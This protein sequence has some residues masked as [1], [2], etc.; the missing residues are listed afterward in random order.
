MTDPGSTDFVPVTD[1]IAVFDNDGTLWNEKPL[2]I[3]LEYEISYI[4]E[5]VKRKPEFKE[6]VLFRELAAGNLAILK[7]YDSFD[8]IHALFAA[9]DGQH[10]EDYNESV[11]NFLTY[12]KHPRFERPYK[13]MVYQPM[14]GL[15][16][17]LQAN[18]FNVFIVTGG[19]ISFARTVSEEIYNIPAEN[20]IGSSIQFRYVSDSSGAYIIRT[21]K[22][23]SANDKHIKPANI[24]L[25]IGKKP[26]FAAGNSDGDY[27]MME[28]TLSGEGPSMAILVHHDD[29]ERE[30][31]YMKGTEKAV[32]DAETKGWHVVSMKND[33]R[34]IFPE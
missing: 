1:R 31:N 8:L 7:D 2:Y 22:I 28:Y 24:E 5:L 9:H 29:E 4:K 14:V 23:I 6:N 13:E 16:D 32:Q 17:Y 27:E 26:I 12:A 30:Y 21:G 25:H 34:I 18:E 11:Y 10:E 20:V 33:F 19:E 3:P 15:V